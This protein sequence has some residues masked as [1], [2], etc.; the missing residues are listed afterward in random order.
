MRRPL[1]RGKDNVERS[2]RRKVARLDQNAAIMSAGSV[3]RAERG[4]ISA[5]L[6]RSDG[7]GKFSEGCQELPR[8]GVYAELVVAAAKV[9]P[10]RVPAPIT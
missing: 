10:E 8:I 9:L 5:V 6:A 2:D 3:A 7:V 4:E 1:A